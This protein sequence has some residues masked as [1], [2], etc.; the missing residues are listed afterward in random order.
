[1]S[2]QPLHDRVLLKRVI[3][4]AQ[5]TGIAPH[6]SI[7][8]ELGLPTCKAEVIEVGPGHFENGQIHPL[9]VAP[10]QTVLIGKYSGTEVEVDGEKLVILPEQDILAIIK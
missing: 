10:G 6:R 8:I 4:K 3:L 9:T 7:L 5:N 1:M 2:L